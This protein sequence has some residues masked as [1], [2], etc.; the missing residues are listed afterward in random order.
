MPEVSDLTQWSKSESNFVCHFSQGFSRVSLPK[1]HANESKLDNTE[2]MMPL[3]IKTS[4][5]ALNDFRRVQDEAHSRKTF[6]STCLKTV[7]L[8]ACPGL[9]GWI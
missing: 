3:L 6:I 1:F 7:Y 9:Q 4:D 2:Y 8:T 5:R